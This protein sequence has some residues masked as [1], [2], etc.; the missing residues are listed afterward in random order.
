LKKIQ[1][2]EKK[3]A[4][5]VK[6][7]KPTEYELLWRNKFLAIDTKTFDEF[8]AVMENSVSQL[9]AMKAD[10]VTLQEE[11]IGDDYAWFH[12]TDPKVAKKYGFNK[13][14]DEEEDD[15]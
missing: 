1:A 2:S 15:D 12:T 7:A 3:V 10:G 4:A 11:G 14:E 8:I 5:A 13:V 9:K 6:A